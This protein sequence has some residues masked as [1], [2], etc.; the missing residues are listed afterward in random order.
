MDCLD[1]LFEAVANSLE[2]G[3]SQLVLDLDRKDGRVEVVLLD[4]G[5]GGD[6]ARAFE[7]GWSTKGGHGRGL[8]LLKEACPD[9]RLER[10]GSWTRL[11]YSFR[12]EDGGRPSTVLPFLFQRCQAGGASLTARS[13]GQVTAQEEFGN[14][15]DAQTL[16]SAR[17]RMGIFDWK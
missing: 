1:F 15:D 14:L 10:V 7:E 2:A 8:W 6:F 13:Q 9:A 16:A 3:A 17:R 5:W 12:E 11:S 4:D